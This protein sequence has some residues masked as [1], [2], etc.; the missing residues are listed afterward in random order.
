MFSADECLG[1]ERSVNLWFFFKVEE[2]FR[3]QEGLD[4]ALFSALVI[5]LYKE[6]GDIM[7]AEVYCGTSPIKDS[8]IHGC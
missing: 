1:E 8:W 2:Y 5:R 7:K 4:I 3:L 6:S